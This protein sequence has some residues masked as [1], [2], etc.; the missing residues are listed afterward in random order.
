MY[1]KDRD[2]KVVRALL[3]CSLY[4]QRTRSL[5]CVYLLLTEFEVRYCKLRTEFFPVRLWPKREARGP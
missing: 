5:R 1:V 3:S 2:K 4:E